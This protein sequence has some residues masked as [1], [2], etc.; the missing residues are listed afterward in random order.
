MNDLNFKYLSSSK[1]D[2]NENFENFEN[3]KIFYDIRELFL[4]YNVNKKN[5]FTIEVEDG[6][7]AP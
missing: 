1:F 7:K 5:M 4:F 3:P 2:F 6:R